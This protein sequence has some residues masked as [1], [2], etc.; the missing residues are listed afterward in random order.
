MRLVVYRHDG[1]LS[2][3]DPAHGRRRAVTATPRLAVLTVALVR[4]D[5]ER[6]LLELQLARLRR[7][8]PGPMT[9]HVVAKRV[10]DDVRTWLAGQPDVA[11]LDPP[12]APTSAAGSTGATSTRSS[13]RRARPTPPTSRPSISTRSRSSTT[14]WAG[15]TVLPPGAGVAAVLRRENG[16]VCLP[17]PSGTV[18]TRAFVEAHTVSF[19]PDTDGTPEFRR[20]LRE[21]GQRA[22]TGIRLAG[23]LWTETIP[24]TPLLRTNAVDVH[25]V[26]AGIYGDCI[27]HLG[28]GSRVALFRADLAASPVHR[29]TRP[30]ERV[31][32]GHGRARA[33]KRRLLDTLRRP[34]ETRAS[35]RTAGPRCAAQLRCCTIPTRSSRASAASIR[36][37]P[38]TPS[39][40]VDGLSGA[41][42]PD[43]RGQRGQ[44]R[45]TRPR[46]DRRRP[47]AEGDHRRDGARRH[48]AARA[49]PHRPRAR[50]R[51][52]AGRPDRRRAAAGL[53][54][55][56]AGVTRP[57]S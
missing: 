14:G 54:L 50:H 33:A 37:R 20:F 18:L 6:A 4:D 5:D 12:A 43:S 40:S 56:A 32:V 16:D 11:L 17:H 47:G 38:R 51:L 34:A 35:R 2:D 52:R 57:A 27:F 30:L 31:P 36:N 44:D 1:E 7:H 15:S 22:D 46:G 41:P 29:L 49:D 13:R 42:A 19:S 28:A 53:E 25:P 45:G 3:P 10:P 9:I 39:A 21:S 24:W 8:T 23:T 26:I 55:P 48:H